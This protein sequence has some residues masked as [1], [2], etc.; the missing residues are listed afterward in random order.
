MTFVSSS[1]HVSNA[2]LPSKHLPDNAVKKDT[3]VRRGH[4]DN[5]ERPSSLVVWMP[6]ALHRITVQDIYLHTTYY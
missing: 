4:Y 1:L 3:V 6:R 2:D 5:G